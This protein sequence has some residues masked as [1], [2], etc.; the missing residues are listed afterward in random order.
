MVCLQVCIPASWRCDTDDD[1]GDNSD[2]LLALCQ[3]IDCE[4]Y[5]RHRCDNGRCIRYNQLCDNVRQ[6]EDGSDENDFN[7]CLRKSDDSGVFVK[8]C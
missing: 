3:A 5:Q 1:C 6:C 8:L 2:E 4:H 7:V